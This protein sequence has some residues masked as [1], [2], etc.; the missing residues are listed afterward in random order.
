[1]EKKQF[2]KEFSPIKIALLVIA[3]MIFVYLLL[4]FIWRQTSP[5]FP[6]KN[7]LDLEVRTPAHVQDWLKRR[8]TGI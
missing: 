4:I 3:G 1:M 8:A 6:P 5:N 7:L 2:N